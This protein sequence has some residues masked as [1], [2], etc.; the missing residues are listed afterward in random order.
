M[1]PLILPG[2]RSRKTLFCL[3]E[4][5]AGSFMYECLSDCVYNSALL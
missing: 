4:G 1:Q 5:V 3:L 2:T